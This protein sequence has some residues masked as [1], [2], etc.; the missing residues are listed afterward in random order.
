MSRYPSVGVRLE[1]RHDTSMAFSW[2]PSG[3]ARPR[4]PKRAAVAEIK[5]RSD[6]VSGGNSSREITPPE[7]RWRQTRLAHSPSTISK[8]CRERV[9]ESASISEPIDAWSISSDSIC[10]ETLWNAILGSWQG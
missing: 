2:S 10:R 5:S 3:S 9:S 6:S 1:P 8:N 4:S 7:A